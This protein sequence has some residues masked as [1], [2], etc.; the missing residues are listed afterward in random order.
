MSKQSGSKQQKGKPPVVLQS[1]VLTDTQC[2]TLIDLFKKKEPVLEK[3]GG[4]R[5][6]RLS[7]YIPIQYTEAPKLFDCIYRHICKANKQFGFDLDLYTTQLSVMQYKKGGEAGWHIDGYFEG[8][9]YGVYPRRKLAVII[10]LNKSNYMQY[11]DYSG[12]HLQLDIRYLNAAVKGL[13]G[14]GL[15]TRGDRK[16]DFVCAG[17]GDGIF[18]P[19]FIWHRVTKVTEGVRYSAVMFIEGEPFK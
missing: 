16:G 8:D 18:L 10:P 14:P 5:E 15:G 19:S 9:K 6:G 2:K 17:P 7:T 12:G 13:I 1:S 11:P 3:F 4:K